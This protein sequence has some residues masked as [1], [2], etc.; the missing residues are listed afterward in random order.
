MTLAI[1]ASAPVSADRAAAETVDQRFF[2]AAR[3]KEQRRI[4]ASGTRKK[5]NAVPVKRPVTRSN[6]GD[7][8][9]FAPKIDEA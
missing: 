8:A 2:G 4:G 6:A 1:Y 9:K 7:R 3:T 5:A